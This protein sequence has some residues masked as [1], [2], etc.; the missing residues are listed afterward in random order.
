MMMEPAR[1]SRSM[2]AAWASWSSPRVERHRTCPA[3]CSG[4]IAA[5][6]RAA[7][8][9][10]RCC[11]PQPSGRVPARGK[12]SGSPG[13]GPVRRRSGGGADGSRGAGGR[14]SGWS[15]GLCRGVRRRRPGAGGGAGDKPQ[16]CRQY[17]CG[18]EYSCEHFH[19][20]AAIWPPARC[21][22]C[23]RLEPPLPRQ[24]SGDSARDVAGR[25]RETDSKTMKGPHE[26]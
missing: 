9:A 4:V 26:D 6:A 24:L 21:Y 12:A 15:R 23:T 7:A 8:S 11:G 1:C 16:N 17:R 10:S 19:V 3:L 2:T 13:V 5:T 22:P 20:F 14:P 25:G 18:P